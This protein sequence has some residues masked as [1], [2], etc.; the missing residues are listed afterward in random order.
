MAAGGA[1]REQPAAVCPA[2]VLP[3]GEVTS[4]LGQAAEGAV[5]LYAQGPF[6]IRGETSRAVRE[7]YEQRQ[8]ELQQPRSASCAGFFDYKLKKLPPPPRLAQS[9]ALGE[10]ESDAALDKILAQFKREANLGK[11]ASSDAELARLA[12]LATRDQAAWRVRKLVSSGSIR[13]QRVEDGPDVGWRI[14]T[15]VAT[16][17][18]TAMPPSWADFRASVAASLAADE[19]ERP[20]RRTPPMARRR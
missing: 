9:N 8:V 2:W 13:T 4:W 19:A 3:L 10:A 11:R 20:R 12:G 5:L 16:G 1:L 14:V 17:R 6:L 18:Q 7:L 15:I